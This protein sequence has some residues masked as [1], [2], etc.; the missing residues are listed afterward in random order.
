M[1]NLSASFGTVRGSSN[2]NV[3]LASVVINR[4]V[5]FDKSEL[6]KFDAQIR[7]KGFKK[8]KTHFRFDE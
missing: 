1:D 6:S 7:M 5:M 4:N 3:F 8:S 2:R